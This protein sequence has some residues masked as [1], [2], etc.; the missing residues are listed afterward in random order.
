MKCPRCGSEKAKRNGMGRGWCPAGRHSFQMSDADAAAMI[1][2][3]NLAMQGVAPEFGIDAPLPAGQRLKGV[4][5]LTDLRSG[6]RV[7][8]WVKSS[9]DRATMAAVMEAAVNAFAETLPREK[10]LARALCTAAND[11]LLNLYIITD[12]HL[13]MLA[14]GEETGAD[15]DLQ[16]A[17]DM[18]VSAIARMIHVSPDAATAVLAILGDF[19]HW[20]GMEAIT[21]QHHN[22]LDA[23]TRFAKL[24][25]VAIRALRR[26]IKMLLEKY[27][28][29]VLLVAEGNH[30]PAS[31]VHLREWL[32]AFYEDNPRV[33]V[34]TR[35]DPYYC[36]EHGRTSLFFHHGHKR[37]LSEIAPVFA[38]KFREVFGRTEHS[39]AHMGHLHCVDVKESP[40]MLVEQHRTLAAPDAYASRGGWLAGRDAQVITY[41]KQFG[42]W[43]RHRVSAQ[44]LTGCTLPPPAERGRVRAGK[45]S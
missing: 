10:P 9:E 4:S 19:L 35:P 29:V 7:L 30:D 20:D 18:L 23:D 12:Y 6:E 42:E 26:I 22:L 3:A 2:E 27:E 28:R 13:G 36:V 21:P 43:E 41:H 8:Q 37:K 32:R 45:G 5:T 39:Y 38:A 14:W 44:A 25:R 24:V 40:L 33:E 1:L 15:W 17:E 31:S 16:I 11:E 34:I